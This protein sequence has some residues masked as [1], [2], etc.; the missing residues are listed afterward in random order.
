MHCL[1]LA[2]GHSANDCH[3]GISCSRITYSCY[4]MVPLCTFQ[5]IFMEQCIPRYFI[6][7]YDSTL[8]PPTVTSIFSTIF[9]PLIKTASILCA[10]SCNISNR[11]VLYFLYRLSYRDYGNVVCKAHNCSPVRQLQS[12]YS[13]VQTWDLLYEYVYVCKWNG[14]VP[15]KSG[16]LPSGGLSRI[17]ISS[18]FSKVTIIVR[19]NLCSLPRL[20]P[21]CL[22]MEYIATYP[23][24]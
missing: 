4:N 24:F 14:H 22:A 21:F 11:C 13:I 1:L 8:V 6:A 19:T 17:K 23:P 10:A 7:L 20:T 16:A 5:R 12:K 18:V 9:Q 3:L 15:T 2:M